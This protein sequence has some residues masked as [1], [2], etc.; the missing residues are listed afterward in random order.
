[1]QRAVEHLVIEQRILRQGEA[2]KRAA[3]D[4]DEMCSPIDGV[5]V[6]STGE[7]S[8][9][10]GSGTGT[11]KIV[12]GRTRLDECLVDTD[13]RAAERAPAGGDKAPGLT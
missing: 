5:G 6:Q 3:L 4:E 13:M 2:T 11:A 9:D 10:S 1:M 8:H 7:A 12:E